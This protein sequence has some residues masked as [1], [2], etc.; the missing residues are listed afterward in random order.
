[1]PMRT[2][3]LENKPP[4]LPPPPC[5]SLDASFFSAAGAA[6]DFF[7][8]LSAIDGSRNR[9]GL[10]GS[11]ACAARPTERQFRY[12][13]EQA[14]DLGAFLRLIARVAGELARRFNR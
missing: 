13:L 2:G 9:G 5:A 6:S 10:S 1:M 14:R 3:V 8:G 7:S 11:N 4:P 12:R